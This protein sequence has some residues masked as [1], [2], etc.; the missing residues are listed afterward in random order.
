MHHYTYDHLELVFALTSTQTRLAVSHVLNL[1]ILYVAYDAMCL[2][3][4]WRLLIT[5]TDLEHWLCTS[6]GIN[7][8]QTQDANLH[9][10]GGTVT[11]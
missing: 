10:A 1:E 11:H 8:S 7:V 4:F 3:F 5:C 9:I 6:L 2:N